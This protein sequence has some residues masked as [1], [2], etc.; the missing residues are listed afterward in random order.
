MG[1]QFGKHAIA[2][3]VKPTQLPAMF[4]ILC[5]SSGARA[6]FGFDSYK[7]FAPTQ[8]RSTLP[9]HIRTKPDLVP[10]GVQKASYGMRAVVNRHRIRNNH[11]ARA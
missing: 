9:S 10:F 6:D 8:L 2:Q 7:D 4:V 5:R 1:A 3:R 11:S